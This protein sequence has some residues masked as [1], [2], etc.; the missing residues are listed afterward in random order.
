MKKYIRTDIS[1]RKLVLLGWNFIFI[2]KFILSGLVLLCFEPDS[3]SIIMS[4]LSLLMSWGQ[5][6]VWLLARVW[7]SSLTRSLMP[8]SLPMFHSINATADFLEKVNKGDIIYVLTKDLITTSS[9][10]RGAM[11]L[12]I[13]SLAAWTWSINIEIAD[14]SQP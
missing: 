2:T 11:R 7:I 9:A 14:N 8:L 1:N 12:D 13:E 3:Y 5:I 10:I 6:N 4:A